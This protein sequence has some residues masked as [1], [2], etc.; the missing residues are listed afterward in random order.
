MT[1]R[2]EARV[3]S[4]ARWLVLWGKG[5]PDGQALEQ[6]VE[7]VREVGAALC[8]A[9]RRGGHALKL[10]APEIRFTGP[11][12]RGGPGWSAIV[13]V[14]VTVD[15][16]EA[17]TA[18]EHAGERWPLARKVRLGLIEGSGEH[19]KA[20]RDAAARSIR[21]VRIGAQSQ[22]RARELR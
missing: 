11:R 12:G 13:R 14:P 20:P 7:A 4:L 5:A 15:E 16:R 10:P 18:A 2:S 8:E 22:H 21:E 19:D 9:R 3:A 6:A 1:T 17:R